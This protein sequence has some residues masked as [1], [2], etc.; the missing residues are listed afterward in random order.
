M[1]GILGS[2]S[3]AADATLSQP[4]G[5]FPPQLAALALETAGIGCWFYDAAADEIVLD[6]GMC[7][8]LRLTG[9]PGRLPLAEALSG[10]G[11]AEIERLRLTMQASLDTAQ[12]FA[13]TLHIDAPMADESA[14]ILALRGRAVDGMGEATVLAG[15]AW[16]IGPLQNLERQLAQATLEDAETALPNRRFFDRQIEREWR[17]SMRERLDLALVLIELNAPEAEQQ[18]QLLW[19]LA[20][21]VRGILARPADFAARYTDTRL[22]MILPRTPV[23]GAEH[24]AG[25]LFA[26]LSLEQAEQVCL[27]VAALTPVET[28][29]GYEVLLARAASAVHAARQQGGGCFETWQPHM[30]EAPQWLD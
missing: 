6:A 10:L 1:L 28:A 21:H 18:A 25:R 9:E 30:P 14:A 11:R 8:L 4:A 2:M 3:S 20:G 29:L 7:Q 27:G 24:L 12:D 16:D 19:Q 22:M 13:E 15:S 23:S 26:E 17:I 5:Q